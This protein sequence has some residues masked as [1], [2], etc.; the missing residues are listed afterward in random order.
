MSPLH[1][2]STLGRPPMSPLPPKQR[3]TPPLEHHRAR[4][5]PTP[6]LHNWS[7]PRGVAPYSCFFRSAY[8][9]A[10]S[11]PQHRQAY[12]IQSIHSPST[13]S[14][15]H[16]ERLG[17]A[18]DP[19]TARVTTGTVYRRANVYSLHYQSTVTVHAES[20]PVRDSADVVARSTGTTVPLSWAT[21][22]ATT[23]DDRT[24]GPDSLFTASTF[25][26]ETYERATGRATVIFEP[27]TAHAGDAR[28]ATHTFIAGGT[29]AQPSAEVRNRSVHEA[30]PAAHTSVVAGGQRLG[31]TTHVQERASGSNLVEDASRGIGRTADSG[32]HVTVRSHV[33]RDCSLTLSEFWN[34]VASLT[35]RKHEGATPHE[36]LTV[37]TRPE[38]NAGTDDLSIR[39]QSGGT[40]GG[41]SASSGRR[42]AMNKGGSW[43]EYMGNASSMTQGPTGA[44]DSSPCP[45][46][47]L[48]LEILQLT[49]RTFERVDEPAGDRL[50]RIEATRTSDAIS[51]DTSVSPTNSEQAT[52][53]PDHRSEGVAAANRGREERSAGRTSLRQFSLYERVV[54]E[55]TRATSGVGACQVKVD[56]RTLERSGYESQSQ[57]S[58]GR[59]WSPASNRECEQGI[60]MLEATSDSSIEY[61][62]MRE[63]E[64]HARKAS[65]Q[66]PLAKV[67][68][69]TETYTINHREYKAH[70]H[71]AEIEE[72]VGN[73][74]VAPRRIVTVE[75]EYPRPEERTGTET[76]GS[77]RAREVITEVRLTGGVAGSDACLAGVGR[78]HRSP[79]SEVLAPTRGGRGGTDAPYLVDQVRT[80]EDSSV[81]DIERETTREWELL[82][83]AQAGRR[84]SETS[85]D[86]GRE[87]HGGRGLRA[88]T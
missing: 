82:D 1:S 10:S 62:D 39:E 77:G 67:Q 83:A 35:A 13:T 52:A 23:R 2:H 60:Q 55:D 63:R 24:H 43:E 3:I 51:S 73:L 71:G 42:H 45:L 4:G 15:S 27:V 30:R 74:L 44:S 17:L 64:G 20:T 84:A 26:T 61:K 22:T 54:T 33:H 16:V 53:H 37:M 21:E 75:D 11:H 6:E 29:F 65:E 9:F 50:A 79:F 31:T 40:C 12:T 78:R 34:G 56:F 36:S 70:H 28:L 32:A 59:S 14:T 25:A 68:T 7:P 81:S 57:R 48:F 38:T 47:D 85:Q 76:R 58:T 87:T 18:R 8:G 86:H 66:T 5:Y 41:V 19:E 46:D 69:P 72:E 49:A 88:R 80:Y